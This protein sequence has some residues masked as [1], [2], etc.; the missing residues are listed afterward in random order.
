[1][2]II[3]H[4][5]HGTYFGSQLDTDADV[6]R[7]GLHQ[8]ISKESMETEHSEENIQI[9]GSAET[10]NDVMELICS[11]EGQSDTPRHAPSCRRAGHLVTF[12]S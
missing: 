7:A 4:R 1:L 11:Q 3:L 12:Q 5:A 8:G 10:V 2:N 9:S 6:A